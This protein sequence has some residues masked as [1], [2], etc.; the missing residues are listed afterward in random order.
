MR[1]EWEQEREAAR[2]SAEN[3]DEEGF[4]LA[5]LLAAKNLDT[6]GGRGC[7]GNREA[8]ILASLAWVERCEGRDGHT[9]YKFVGDFD[10]DGSGHYFIWDAYSNEIFC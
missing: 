7:I 3:P 4:A 10:N 8:E 5:C 6:R 9:A 1:E 2:W